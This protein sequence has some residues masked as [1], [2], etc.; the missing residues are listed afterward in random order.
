MKW[1]KKV[2]FVFFYMLMVDS[3]SEC[4]TLRFQTLFSFVYLFI[5]RIF[6]F[7]FTK[8][9]FRWNVIFFFLYDFCYLLMLIYM[10]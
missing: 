2:Y 7:I 10:L 1:S 4:A 6:Y 5:E 3:N 9:L 8:V